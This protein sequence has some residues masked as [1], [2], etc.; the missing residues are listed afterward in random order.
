[1][2]ADRKEIGKLSH[3]TTTGSGDSFFLS[4]YLIENTQR[5]F[6]IFHTRYYNMHVF[7]RN[8]SEA[9]FSGRG[10]VIQVRKT[11]A[12]EGLQTKIYKCVEQI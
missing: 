3:G 12:P 1:V 2:S 4:L 11:A 8:G 10:G 7:T 9:K 5:T 6:A